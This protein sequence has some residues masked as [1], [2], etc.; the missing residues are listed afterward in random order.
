MKEKTVQTFA[1]T[2]L[3]VVLAMI[4][5]QEKVVGLKPKLTF[6]NAVSVLVG[7]II[8]SG[9]FIAPKGVLS[10]AGSTNAALL[11][12]LGCGIFNCIGAHCWIELGCMIRK[13]GA[14]YNYILE[15]YGKFAGFLHLWTDCVIM[16][17]CTLTIVCLG[18]AKYVLEP[19]FMGCQVPG[20][21]EQITAALALLL[22]AAVNSYNLAWAVKVQQTFA[23]AKVAAL[24][25]IISFGLYYVLFGTVEN[26]TFEGT[27][28]DVRKIAICF[29][30]G[31]WSFGGWGNLN[32]MIEEMKNPLKHLPPAMFISLGIV[33]IVYILA[34]VAFFA[35]IPTPEILES[36]A[37][38]QAFAYRAFG[39]WAWIMP[40]FVAMSTLGS[41]NGNSM[42]SSRLFF[43]GAAE[44][45]LPQI[46]VTLNVRSMIPM[47]AVIFQTAIAL[48][49]LSYSDIMILIYYSALASWISSLACG[50][51]IPWLRWKHPDLPRP[52]KVHLFWPMLFSAITVALLAL[53]AM[54]AP[55]ETCF[56]V[57]VIL[58][59]VPFYIGLLYSKN[60][61]RSLMKASVF[62]TKLVQKV[63]L[64][65]P[66]D[67]RCVF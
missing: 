28:T 15:A 56:G 27:S 67:D 59:G 55:A 18:F 47:P 51:A 40:L 61:P 29:F 48:V 36:E 42:A 54:E 10:G 26:F 38:A 12:W 19:F 49:Y 57:V 52:F 23:F 21:L 9:I 13:S 20:N 62:C 2:R 34:N 50:L 39:V 31:L 11:V 44:G 58:S 46:L 64:V 5:N 63:L 7:S 6:L 37:V 43:A 16:R 60:L 14:D 33:T 3:E 35:V 8:G 25:L 4:E 17:P 41:A 45:H 1:V 65:L 32:H 22:L 24:V 66:P 53:S 30:P